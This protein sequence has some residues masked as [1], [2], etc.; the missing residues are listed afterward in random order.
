MMLAKSGVDENELNEL[1]K[2]QQCQALEYV[3]DQNGAFLEMKNL[4]AFAKSVT[5]VAHKG[6]V[7]YPENGLVY[8]LTYEQSTY[9]RDKLINSYKYFMVLQEE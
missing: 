9:I 3:I 7:L 8:A 5:Q 6:I 4:D 1:L 2:G